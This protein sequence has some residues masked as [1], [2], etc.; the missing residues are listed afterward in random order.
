MGAPPRRYWAPTLQP[1]YNRWTGVAGVGTVH[2]STSKFLS[3]GRSAVVVHRRTASTEHPIRAD[4]FERLLDPSVSSPLVPPCPAFAAQSTDKRKRNA[5]AKKKT[6]RADGE[7]VRAIK[8][9]LLPTEEQQTVLRQWFAAT[10]AYYNQT[11]EILNTVSDGWGEEDYTDTVALGDDD[12]LGDG[13]QDAFYWYQFF[14]AEQICAAP[15]NASYPRF[16]NDQNVPYGN[17]EFQD[18]SGLRSVV[19]DLLRTKSPWVDD[20]P[21]KIRQHAVQ[22]AIEARDTNISKCMKNPGQHHFNLRFRSLRNLTTTP[23]ERLVIDATKSG[24]C[25]R[26][27][28]ACDTGRRTGTT[29]RRRADVNVTLAPTIF[30]TNNPVRARDSAKVVTWLLQERTLKMAAELLWDKR[31]NKFFLVVKHTVVRAAEDRP[32]AAQVPV[33][34]D[35]GTRTFQTACTPDGTWAEFAVGSAK[36]YM[37][38]LCNKA[39]RTQTRLDE[40]PKH[41]CFWALRRTLRGRLRRLRRKAHNW[42][43]HLHYEVIR[44]LFAMGD[45]FLCP[46]F[47]NGKMS[48][49]ATRI[50]NTTVAREMYTWAHG[51]FR[52][53]LWAKAQITPCK[54]VAFVYEPGTTRTCDCCGHVMPK[55]SSAVFACD[56]CGHRAPRD[57]HGARGNALA[58]MGAACDVGWDEVER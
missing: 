19:H 48:E 21:E 52:Q 28:T 53:R 2:V 11:V 37:K 13:E 26:A 7:H 49:R 12:R 6:Q 34:L 39:G 43:K 10:R 24:G 1:L 55:N 32:L 54:A 38:Y 46:I 9:R 45:L 14:R 44:E 51:Y 33:A 23:T 18:E 58:A 25:L 50:F 15:T 16:Q 57:A 20:V 36:G 3:D 29:T 56:R 8:I 22:D 5:I 41:R 30:G 31:V 4:C 40:L 17:S 47:E 27:F 35:P 42:M